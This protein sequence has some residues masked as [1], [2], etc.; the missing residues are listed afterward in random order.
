MNRIYKLKFDKRRNE[1]VVVSEITAGMGKEKSTGHIADLPALSPFRKL[2]GTLT[3]VS[4]LTGLI[5]GLLPAMVLAA[6]LPTGGQIVGG[7]GS[8][9]TSGNQMTIHQQTQN[10]ATNW[11]SFDIGKNNT[12]QFVQPDSSSVALNRVTGASGSQIMGTLKANGQVFILNP[13]GVLFGKNARVDVGGLVAST[14]NISTADFMKGQYTLSGEG[15]PGAQVINQGSLTTSKGGYIVL[16]GERVSNSGTV[17]TPGG[18]TVLAAGKTVTLQLDN[19]GLTS[20]SV[21]GSVVNALVENRGLISASNGQVYLTAKGQDMLLN[22]VVNNS[23]TVEAKGLVSRAGEIVLDGGDSGVVSQSGQLL[24]DSQTGQGGKITLEGQNIHLAGGSLT[25]ATGKTGGG[26]VYVGGGWQGKDSRIRNASKVVMDKTAM[27]DVSATEAGNGGTAVLWSDDYTNFRGTVLAKGGSQSGNGGRVE[28]SSHRNLQASGTV[29]ASSPSGKGGEWLLD[30]TDVTIV[31]SGADSNIDSTTNAGIFTPT[32]SG[33]Q[34]LNTSIVSQLNAGTNVTVK[35]S[36]TDTGGQTGNITVN[37]DIV[38]TAGA[39]TKLTLLADNNIATADNV[40]IGATTGKLNLDLLAGNTTNNASIRLGTRINISLN[41]GGLLAN[42]GSANNGVS[43]MFT[44]NGQVHGGNVTLNLTRGL[45]GYAYKVQADN[46][47]TINGPVSGSTG[48]SVP[49]NFIAGGKL[50][51]NSPE[52]IRLVAAETTNGGGRVVIQGDKGVS[53]NT[54]AGNISLTAASATTNSVNVSSDNGAVSMSAVGNIELSNGN[55]SAKGNITLQ[56]DNGTVLIS[57][58]NATAK[59]SITSTDNDIVITGNGGNS[60]GVRLINANLTSN[61]M[62]INGNTT[63]GSNNDK[64]P[65]GGVSLLGADEFHVADTGRGVI[66]GDVKNNSNFSMAGAVVIGQIWQQSTNVVFDGSFDING[67][68]TGP[69]NTPDFYFPDGDATITFKGGKS[70]MTSYGNGVLAEYSGYSVAHATKFILDDADFSFNVLSDSAPSPG[71]VLIGDTNYNSYTSGFV[72]SGNGNAQLNI[73]ASSPDS[74][75]YANRLETNNLHGNFSLNV[76]NDIGDAIVMLGR[77]TMNLV[78]ASI[79]GI[80]STGA[81]IRLEVGNNSSVSLGNNTITGISDT[82]SGIQLTGNN[83]T[84]TDG[85]LN[86]SSGAGDGV[87]VSGNAT[88]TNVTVSGETQTGTGAVVTGKLTADDTTQVTGKATQEGGTGVTLNG[89]VT[90]GKV[91][92][93]ATSG[94][95]VQLAEG[96]VLTNAVVTG[97]ASTGTGLNVSGNATLTNATVSGETQTG[98]GAVVSGKLTADD[99]TQVKGNAKQDSG[100]GVTLNGTVTGGKVDGTATSGDAVRVTDGGVLTNAV[101]TGNASTGTGLNV[102]GNATLTNATVS[103]ETQTGTGAVV[104]GKLT[105]DDTTQVTGKATQEGGTGVTLNG[106]VTGGKVDGTATSGDA[107]RVTDGGVLTNAVVTGNASTGTGLNV[108]GNATLTNATVSGTT[109]TGTGAVVTG[110]LTITDGVSGVTAKATGNGTGLLMENATLQAN[111]Y[112]GPDKA[113]AIVATAEGAGGTAIKI[114]GDNH[115]GYV[116]ITGNAFSVGGTGVSLGGQ[117]SFAN[118]KGVADSGTAV[119]VADGTVLDGGAVHGS[120]DNGTGLAADGNVTLNGAL[121]SGSVRGSGTGVSLKGNITGGTVTGISVSSG[122]AVQIVDSRLTDT[123][124]KGDSQTGAGVKT[125][126]NVTLQGTELSATSEHGITDLDVSGALN[127]DQYSVIS[128]DRIAGQE[129]IHVLQP[130][131]PPSPEEGGAT[132]GGGNTTPDT[133]DSGGVAGGDT[134]SGES[135]GTVTPPSGG[136]GG[137]AGNNGNTGSTAG[138]EGSIPDNNAAQP[139]GAPGPAIRE[140]ILVSALRQQA[141]DAQV[142]RMNQATPDGFHSAATP[143]VPVTGYQAKPQNVEINLCDEESCQPEAL[144]AAMPAEG[145]V[146]SS[147]K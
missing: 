54:V 105:A 46:D 125:Q 56:T 141:V 123:E 9:S 59:A 87:V 86:G 57:G 12:V 63:G 80:S 49:L 93:T 11:H 28:T 48:W 122:D 127:R 32:A 134:G 79:T 10:M 50:T 140:Q 62:D 14:K 126:G 82:G 98:T 38:K 112:V 45:S 94:D 109:E 37:A 120:S 103:G 135:G 60:I 1:L 78:N 72:F 13:N 131:T 23:G 128:A 41:G 33:A 35:T 69:N 36:G 7:Q 119:A 61:N 77:T 27:V 3:P 75:F 55:I 142:T 83:I 19:G 104:T 43:L 101:V 25:S 40:S 110:K 97:N 116:P 66:N 132:G 137:D 16:A 113:H 146:T 95:A 114:Q 139:G 130:D 42:A 84:L 64:I 34:I 96:V 144:D 67:R 53:L 52:D 18:K 89:T 20:V 22:T 102:S 15:N 8:I 44:N 47:L 88:L 147:G 81:G 100:T 70:S 74:A 124:V 39:D 129:N 51:I 133:G 31:G 91:D 58:A 71:V 73:H 85:T 6:D 2:L 30:P 107:V 21:N 4:L 68:A 99:T 24:A 65:F 106:T 118:I 76:T 143:V 108:S 115:L 117:V 138:S 111:G 145:V 29:D 5:S 90:G 26:E 92:G 136:T 121:I 17:T